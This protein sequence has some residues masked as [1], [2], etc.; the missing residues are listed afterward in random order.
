MPMSVT[1][2]TLARLPRGLAEA[3]WTWVAPSGTGAG[4]EDTSTTVGGSGVSAHS[5]TPLYI[6][7][8]AACVRLCTLILRRIALTWTFTV[9]SVISILRAITLLGSPS[10]TQRRMDFSLAD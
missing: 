5:G 2:A 3:E 8:I 10:T 4:G 9:A 1:E 7:Q 6:A